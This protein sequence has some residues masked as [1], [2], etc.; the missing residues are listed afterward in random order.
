M[1]TP[2]IG[3]LP[4]YVR[5][6]DEVLPNLIDEL[7]PFLSE[8]SAALVSIGANVIESPVCRIADEVEDAVRKFESGGAHVI[9]TLHLAYS[10]S[11]EAA[12]ALA[13]CPLPILMLDTTPDVSFGPDVDPLRLLYNHGI[14]GV[15][16]LSCM[17]RRIGKPYS[18]V[19]GHLSDPRT[20]SRVE[21]VVRGA[22]A[23]AC[24]RNMRILRIGPSFTG[25]GDFYVTEGRLREAFN[26]EIVQISTEDL[27]ESVQNVSIE[28][29][30]TEL[31]QDQT[32]FDVDLDEAVHRRS[33]RLGLGVRQ[34]LDRGGFGA[35]SMNFLAF[36]YADGPLSTVPFLECSKA[37][38]RGIGYAGEGDVLTAALV[39]AMVKAMGP[40]TFTE[41]FCPDWNGDTLFL[42][43]MGEFNPAMSAGRPRLYEKP[44]PFTRTQNPAAIAC[45]PRPGLATLVNISPGSNDTFRILYSPVEVLEDGNHPDFRD[46]IRGWIKPRVPVSRFLEAY[47]LC[48]G[49]HHCCLVQGDVCTAIQ[50]FAEA[51][52]LEAVRVDA[53]G[54]Y[55]D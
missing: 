1:K 17:L 32:A 2:V 19:A 51:L 5:L 18:V 45:A 37:M 48:G 13:K 16:D 35:F 53:Q 23:A 26:Q 10:P 7:R 47:S 8:V 29:I 49:T 44:F 52:G 33:V 38:A 43:H 24:F 4:L 55:C 20:M 31:R 6:Y 11:L 30:E 12:N 41:M 21:S 39:A 9:V 28:E 54:G 34:Y 40:A 25:M 3:L 14:H 36:G 15:Q 22:H 42:S 50:A 46:W 27:A